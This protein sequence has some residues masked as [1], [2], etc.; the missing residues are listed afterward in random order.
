M[1]S[2]V[3]IS[4][5]GDLSNKIAE[6]LRK[7]L[8][9]VLQFVKPYFTP[10]DIDKGTRWSTEIA[11]EL[12]NCD[13]GII[14][15]TKDNIERPWILFEA[16]ALSKKLSK[17]NVCTL[18][19]NL[20]PTDISGPL[21]SFRSTKFDKIDFKKL[22]STINNTNQDHK[23]EQTVFDEVYEMWWPKIEQN[24]KAILESE[25]KV[26]KAKKR[27]DRDLI[28]EILELSRA[29]AERNLRRTNSGRNALSHLVELI[30]EYDFKYNMEKE[31]EHMMRFFH[32]VR[33]PIKELCYEYD[34]P[35]I[36]DK[37][38]NARRRMRIHAAEASIEK[39]DE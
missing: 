20:E 15:L 23:L 35:E 27:S 26:A 7:W 10:N 33:M 31:D 30:A 24:I 14:C 39:K 34:S 8:P 29:N 38:F 9:G 4:W 17:S 28:E 19:F 22:I 12:E 37:Y 21:A 3:F 36:Y 11:E 18:L 32:M 5:S 25:N 6:E 16:G 1:S 2:K 13:V